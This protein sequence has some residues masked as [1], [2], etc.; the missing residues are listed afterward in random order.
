MGRIS[1]VGAT[2][3]SCVTLFD[4]A[5]LQTWKA[6]GCFVH[7]TPDFYNQARLSM[8]YQP[9]VKSCATFARE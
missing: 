9:A 3:A 1:R 2:S 4:T 8:H 5:Q 6:E 7:E